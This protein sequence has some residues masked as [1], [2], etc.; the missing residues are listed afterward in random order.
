MIKI[1]DFVT[2]CDAGYWQL[3]DIKP[4]IAYE[5][6]EGESVRWK[7][8]DLLGQWV[9]LKKAFTPKLKPRIEFTYVDSAWLRP[10]SADV[11]AEISRYFSEH[12][13]YKEKF[14]IAKMNLRPMITNCWLNLPQECEADFQEKIKKLPPKYTM[15]EFWDI[16][17]Q[18]KQYVSQPPAKYLLNFLSY[19]WD[20]DDKANLLFLG[21][22][23][24]G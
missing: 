5:D 20:L 4:K 14:D 8:G 7:K 18:Y 24:E 19:P 16:C 15:D 17:K 12:P 23:L 6:Y 1:G 2:S 11:Q 3:I 13:E 21:V 10:V 9:I 22:H